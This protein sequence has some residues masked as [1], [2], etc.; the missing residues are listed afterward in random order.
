MPDTLPTPILATSLACVL[1]FVLAVVVLGPMCG[2]GRRHLNLSDPYPA[3]EPQFAPL[4]LNPTRASPPPSRAISSCPGRASGSFIPFLG[5][6][7]LS[8]HHP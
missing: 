4:S 5:T 2:S 1:T 7:L 6:L 8:L 3:P